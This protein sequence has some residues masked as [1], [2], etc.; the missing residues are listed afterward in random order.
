[1]TRAYRLGYGAAQRVTQ[2]MERLKLAHDLRS[3]V[4]DF[5]HAR[6]IASESGDLG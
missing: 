2:L 4:N 1:M 5:G 3:E 6:G